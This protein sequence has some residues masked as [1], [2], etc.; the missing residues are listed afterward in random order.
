MTARKEKYAVKAREVFKQSGLHISL[1][2]I[3]ERT[4]VTKKTL[5]NHFES[6]EGLLKFC[7]Q[8]LMGDLEKRIEVFYSEEINAIEGLKKGIYGIGQVFSSLSPV[9]FYDLKRMFPEM[10]GT[11]H[12]AGFGFFLEGMKSNL[13][14]G[15][16]EK[17]YREDLNV[18]LISKFFINSLVSFFISNVL[19]GSEYSAKEYFESIIDYHLHAIVTEKGLRLINIK[20]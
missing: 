17:L 10:A 9:F 14:K 1:D 4:G 7:M 20:K 3:A 19:T 16:Q 11:Q 5:Y 18:D 6:K 2:E 8:S 13:E 12:R 15:I